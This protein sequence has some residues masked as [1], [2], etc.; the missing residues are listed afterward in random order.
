MQLKL[1]CTERAAAS[2][3]AYADVVAAQLS[4]FVRVVY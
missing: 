1:P 3:T 4:Q 2:G